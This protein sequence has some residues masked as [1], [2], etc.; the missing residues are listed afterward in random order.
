MWRFQAPES[1]VK[2]LAMKL[3]AVIMPKDTAT[4]TGASKTT[5]HLAW[6]SII[7]V[8]PMYENTST[9]CISLLIIFLYFLLGLDFISKKEES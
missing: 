3:F 6:S 7:S 4:N 9:R 2:L 8:Y 1:Q 5:K